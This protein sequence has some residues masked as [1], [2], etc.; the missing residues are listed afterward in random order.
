MQYLNNIPLKD[1][2][3]SKRSCERYLYAKSFALRINDYLDVGYIVIDEKGEVVNSP[4]DFINNSKPV[5]AR[6]YTDSSSIIYYG[7]TFTQDTHKIVFDN[8]NSTKSKIKELFNKFKI[9]N[10]KDIIRLK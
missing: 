8:D 4:F 10:P 2:F 6:T 7:W 3:N 1:Y 9:V 5:I